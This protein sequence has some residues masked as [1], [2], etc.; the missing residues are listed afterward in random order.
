MTQRRVTLILASATGLLGLA[1][2]ALS[3]AIYPN[4][5][6]DALWFVGTG[7]AIVIGAAA[8]LITANPVNRAGQYAKLLI[9]LMMTGFFA[10]AWIVLPGPQ[11]ILGGLLF[12]GL[13][14]CVVRA[15]FA[16]I[17]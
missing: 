17:S 6:V 4:W 11:V 3:M 16:P 14:L 2:L 10:A 5:T 9:N 1:H 12:A 8:N 7:F 15:K 13:A